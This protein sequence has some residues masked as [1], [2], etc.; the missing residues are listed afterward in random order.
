VNRDID[1]LGDQIGA[2]VRKIELERDGWIAA[3]KLRDERSQERVRESDGQRRAQ[4]PARLGQHVAELL[5]RQ[6]S[7]IDDALTA[8]EIDPTGFR[9]LDPARRAVQQTQTDR[10]FQRG[11][12]S[13][14]SG[15]GHPDRHGGA[16]KAHCF[17]D[18]DE[19]RHV[20]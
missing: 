4:D 20:A 9:Q 3:G 7:F 8:F 5:M 13:G 2:P 14:Q 19:E 15:V 12:P 17:H 6:P 10:L 18:F 1:G 16:A 11:N